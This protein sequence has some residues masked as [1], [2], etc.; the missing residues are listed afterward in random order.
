MNQCNVYIAKY[1]FSFKEDIYCH[2]RKEEIEKC[3]NSDVKEQKFYVWKLLEY[4]LFDTFGLEKSILNF[5]KKNNGKWILDGY[6]FSL[7]HSGNIVVVAV[8]DSPIGVDIQKIK[9]IE[10]ASKFKAIIF[11]EKEKSK[12]RNVND[13]QLM[14]IWSLKECSFKKSN[15]S[16]FAPNRY[17]IDTLSRYNSLRMESQKD[18]YILST[19]CNSINDVKY[20]SLFDEFRLQEIGKSVFVPVVCLHSKNNAI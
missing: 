5:Q 12:Y 8:S 7:S 16:N 17:E 13:E 20:Y 3:R 2:L 6:F 18:R 15:D 11:S 19:L 14:Q 10:D 4:A 1:P 9:K